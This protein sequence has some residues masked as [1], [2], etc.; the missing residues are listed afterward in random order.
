MMDDCLLAIQLDETYFKAF[1][2]MGEACV[3]LGKSEKYTDL[4]MIDK[5]IEYL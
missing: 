4:V 1:L 2:T 5:G 3:E